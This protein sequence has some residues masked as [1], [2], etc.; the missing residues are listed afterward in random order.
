[1]RKLTRR[2]PTPAPR[3]RRRRGEDTGRSFKRAARKITRQVVHSV[4]TPLARSLPLPGWDVV[5]WLQQ[6]AEFHDCA[7][8]G[9]LHA[10]TDRPA[11]A[12]EYSSLSP[13]P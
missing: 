2:C 1:M 7:S 8:D 5:S 12:Q 13:Q 9:D 6:W 3:S 10:E 11:D 4:L